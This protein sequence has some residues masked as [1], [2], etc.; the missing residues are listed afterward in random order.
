MGGRTLI[1][2]IFNNY[3]FFIF[4]FICNHSS[5]KGRAIMVSVEPYFICN[6][7][8]IM[9]SVEPYFIYN[10]SPIMDSVELYFICNHSPIKGRAIM[11]SVEPYFKLLIFC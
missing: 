9:V 4:Y 5:I 11:V 2:N 10:H 8:P 3:D 1:I 6:Y 7:F